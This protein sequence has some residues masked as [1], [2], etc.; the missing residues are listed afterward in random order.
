[1]DD[2][3]LLNQETA[4]QLHF[5]SSAMAAYEFLQAA[6]SYKYSLTNP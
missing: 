4:R 6:D 5:S 2:L 1:M 3:E